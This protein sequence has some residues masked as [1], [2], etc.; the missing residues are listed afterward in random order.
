MS[1]PDVPLGGRSHRTPLSA[2]QNT[3]LPAVN[4]EVR[5]IRLDQ[6]LLQ[7]IKRKSFADATK[8][9]LNPRI[10]ERNRFFYSHQV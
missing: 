3:T 7:L 4:Q 2:R 1:D 8:V 6:E 9:Q 5:A 10:G